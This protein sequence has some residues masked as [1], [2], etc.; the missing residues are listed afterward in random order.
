ML[1][2]SIL[3]AQRKRFVG[4]KTAVSF[5][6][7]LIPTLWVF[8]VTEYQLCGSS[9]IYPKPG[10]GLLTMHEYHYK[11]LLKQ[12]T[13]CDWPGDVRPITDAVLCK[14]RSDAW[15]G[16]SSFMTSL[17][18]LASVCYLRRQTSSVEFHMWLTVN[19]SVNWVFTLLQIDYIPVFIVY[20]FKSALFL[21]FHLFVCFLWICRSVSGVHC[22]AFYRS[23]NSK[24][25][26]FFPKNNL[27]G[28]KYN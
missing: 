22:G 18:T 26:F 1:V 5:P 4:T 17:V 9:A 23:G 27:Q 15:W 3:F 6:G 12:Q 7:H 8:W 2:G 20:I 14:I 10:F 16:N 13:V 25:T 21:R 24:W 11:W 28:G 19:I